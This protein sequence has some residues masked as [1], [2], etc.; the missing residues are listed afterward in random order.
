MSDSDVTFVFVNDYA[1]EGRDRADIELDHSGDAL[2][3]SAVNSS[4]N[5]IVV[6]HIPG[7]VDVEK[8]IDNE[9]VTAV[10]AAWFPGEESGDSLVPVLWGDVA[11][12]GKLPF[13]WGRNL[14]DYP[15]SFFCSS[16]NLSS[17]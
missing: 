4:S 6:M 17:P 11:P 13:T 9:N 8:W 12:S 15:V 1:T 7:V 2:I 10:V 3:A 5:V 16:W 14:S